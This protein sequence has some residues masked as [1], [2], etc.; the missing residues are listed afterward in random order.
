MFYPSPEQLSQIIESSEEQFQIKT[1]KKD[2]NLSSLLFK[3]GMIVLELWCFYEWKL[4]KKE[5]LKSN[6]QDWKSIQEQIYVFDPSYQ[7]QFEANQ[8]KIDYRNSF[9]IDWVELSKIFINI[10]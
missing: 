1:G 4:N 8:N 3:L 6:Y 2:V 9:K 5:K 10:E 7:S